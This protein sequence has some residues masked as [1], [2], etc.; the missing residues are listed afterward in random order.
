MNIKKFA[1]AFIVIYVMLSLPAMLGIGYV[2]DWIPEASVF[3]KIKGYAIEGLANN[4]L[5]KLV[6]SGIISVLIQS[7]FYKVR[8]IEVDDSL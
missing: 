8:N 6:V 3:Q 1:F 5:F 4:Y 7:Y 2:I